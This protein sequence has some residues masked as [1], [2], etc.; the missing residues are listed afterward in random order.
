MKSNKAQGTIIII[1]VKG[2][3]AIFVEAKHLF[4]MEIFCNNINVF[5][6]VTFDQF[7]AE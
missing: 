5:F 1:N 6:C 2:T 3:R 7:N 4:E